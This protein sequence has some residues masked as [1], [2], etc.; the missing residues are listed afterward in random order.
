MRG[1]LSSIVSILL[2]FAGSGLLGAFAWATWAEPAHWAAT[3][4]GLVMTESAVTAQF[5]VVAVFVAVGLVI[6]VLGGILTQ[7][8]I[9]RRGPDLG[10][11]D[12]G[13]MVVPIV[14][15]GALIAALVAWRVGVAFGPPDPSSATN[16]N[17]GDTV[18]D[19]L[20][21]D[22]PTAFFAWALA[23]VFGAGATAWLQSP[24]DE[25][26]VDPADRLT[27]ERFEP[28]SHP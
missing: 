1:P 17:L 20:A 12:L 18:P 22:T 27:H 23:A 10:W 6:G 9:R 11:P 5:Q 3:E 4:R 25:R 7:V 28:P 14:A 2:V 13:W 8:W 15:I 26:H 19:R 16:L 24:D 21:I